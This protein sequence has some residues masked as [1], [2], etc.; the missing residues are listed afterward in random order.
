MNEAKEQ[1]RARREDRR[2]KRNGQRRKKDER[3]VDAKSLQRKL[4][5]EVERKQ[6][7]G[8]AKRHMKGSLDRGRQVETY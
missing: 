7:G 3:H 1:E 2:R 4:D 6:K 8:K 5:R